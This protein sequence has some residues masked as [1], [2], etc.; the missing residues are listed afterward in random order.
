V[1]EFQ[2]NYVQEIEVKG[3]LIDSMIL[4]R[5]FD[6]IMDL[7]G[8]FEVLEFR[9]GKRKHEHSYARLLVKGKNEE[10]LELM[11]KQVYSE[12]AVPVKIREVKL[13]QA[14][15]DMVLPDDF[16][17][18]TNNPTFVYIRGRWIEVD[19]LMMDKPIIVQ[20]EPLKAYCKP[21]RDVKKGELVVVGEQGVR[22]VPPERPRES[23]GAFE[24]MSSRTSSEKPIPSVAKSVAED[25]YLNKRHDSKTIVVAGPAVV[26]TGAVDALAWLIRN[27]YVDALLSGNALAVHDIEYALFGTSLGVDVKSGIRKPGGHKNH[28]AAINEVLKHGSIRNMVEKG[29]LK[30]GI[31]Y[32]CIKNNVPFVLASSIRD[33]GPLPEVIIDVIEAQ[34]RYREALKGAKIVLMLA[35]TLHSIAVGNMLPSTVKVIAVD[36]NHATVTKLLDRGTGQALGIISDVGTFLP[37]LSQ[38]LE[39]LQKKEKV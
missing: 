31:F 26:H 38:K 4:T 17:S 37:I 14:P 9:I 15:K 24:F 18:T 32:E 20:L 16:Y 11:L 19:D 36:I 30:S 21:I 22:V 29:I 28:M 6:I 12:G 2:N 33:D 39:E 3:H 10:H 13:E 5:I 7:G 1:R 8:D 34:K 35:T 25:L 23:I 27:G